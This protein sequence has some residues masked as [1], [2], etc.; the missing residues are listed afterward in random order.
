MTPSLRDSLKFYEP[1]THLCG[2]LAQL[3]AVS[4]V[5]DEA[6]IRM[7]GQHELENR[8]PMRHYPRRVGVN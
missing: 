2:Q 6:G 5:A 7:T 1:Y 4:L 3:A 8:F